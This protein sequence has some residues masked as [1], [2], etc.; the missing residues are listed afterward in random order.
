M[1]NRQKLIKANVAVFGLA[2]GTVGY[3]AE[4]S[5]TMAINAGYATDATKLRDRL[6]KDAFA[7]EGPVPAKGL[8]QDDD[9]AEV[10]ALAE[11]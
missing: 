4:S 11:S 3:V 5:A 7:A 9:P 2:A 8:V 1:S 6:S 10:R